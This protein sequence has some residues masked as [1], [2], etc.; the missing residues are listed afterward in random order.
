[1]RLADAYE[2]FLLDLDGVLYRGDQRIEGAGETV[3]KL[4]A[5]DRRVVF[6]TNNSARTPEQVA[7]KLERAGVAASADDVVTSADATADLVGRGHDGR[8]PTAFVIGQDGIRSALEAA[9][10]EVLDGEPGEAGFVVVGWD[11]GVTYD[12]I[13]RAAVLVRAGARLVATNA[14]ASYPAPGGELWPGAGAILAAVETASG[15]RATVVGKPQRP[16]FDAALERAGTRNALVVGDRLE[17]DVAGAAAAG[18]DAAL[19]LTGAATPAELLDHNDLPVAVLDDVSGLLVERPAGHA[20]PAK[21]EDL[22]AIRAL[23]AADGD[24]GGP[25]G[26][27]VIGDGEPL[28][29][30]TLEVREGEAYLRAVAVR[31]DLRGLHLGQLVVAAAVRDARAR[32]AHRVWLLTETAEAFFAGLGFEP[33]DRGEVPDWIRLGPGEGCPSGAVAMRRALAGSGELRDE[34]EVG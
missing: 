8:A 23:V 6:V 5:I 26:I 22:G 20:R 17:T 29:T 11:G 13:R 1:M 33:C 14:D 18:V 21:E 15:E 3:E 31:E 24:A 25:D 12:D 4:R 7:A 28:A 9:G 2:A 27:C 34:P 10:V 30:A 19:V 32:D 16:L